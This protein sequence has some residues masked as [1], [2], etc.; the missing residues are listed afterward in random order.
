[1]LCSPFVLAIW[2]SHLYHIC[3][4]LRPVLH[5]KGQSRKFRPLP[6]HFDLL[7]GYFRG[8]NHQNGGINDTVTGVF[9]PCNCIIYTPILR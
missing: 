4:S 2:V 6:P 1:M 3:P 5:G 8:Q 9:H 7:T